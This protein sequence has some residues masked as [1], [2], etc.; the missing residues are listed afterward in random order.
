MNPILAL[1]ASY[2]KEYFVEDSYTREQIATAELRYGMETAREVRE[3]ITRGNL[4]ASTSVAAALLLHYASL[5]LKWWSNYIFPMLHTGGAILDATLAMA[6]V[7]ILA[8]TCLP[9]DDKHGFQS[10]DYS[11][12]GAG[13]VEN[14]TKVNS[15]LGLSQQM[16]FYIYWI[17]RQ[18][19]VSN[20]R[21]WQA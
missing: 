5:N 11:R 6:S 1:S 4:S 7:S 13:E 20:Q 18:A 15:T 9:L 10:F 12:L 19:K 3:A 17:T 8:A 21:D 16:L 2:L 14:L